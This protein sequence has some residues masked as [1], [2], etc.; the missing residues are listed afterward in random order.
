MNSSLFRNELGKF[1][2]QVGPYPIMEVLDAI[3]QPKFFETYCSIFQPQLVSLAELFLGFYNQFCPQSDPTC[4]SLMSKPLYYDSWVV[5]VS[6]EKTAS[7]TLYFN[8][9][10]A[11]PFHFYQSYLLD[12]SLVGVKLD[13][14]QFITSNFDSLIPQLEGVEKPTFD[15][16]RLGI[17]LSTDNHIKIVQIIKPANFSDDNEPYD[18][19]VDLESVGWVLP[20]PQVA[21]PAE[22]VL[23]T[24][25][26]ADLHQLETQISFLRESIGGISPIYYYKLN[27]SQ[28]KLMS[29][30]GISIQLGLEKICLLRD[31]LGLKFS[32]QSVG[33]I[34]IN[35]PEIAN[36]H[37]LDVFELVGI[38]KTDPVQLL[39]GNQLNFS[40]SIVGV[41]QVCRV[42]VLNLTL[43]TSAT[44][45][46]FQVICEPV[47]NMTAIFPTKTGIGIPSA[48][49]TSLDIITD[50]RG[51]CVV[52]SNHMISLE[53]TPKVITSSAYWI[54][55][56]KNLQ[57]NT[58]LDHEI[59]L[60]LTVTDIS[61][62]N[63]TLEIQSVIEAKEFLII[64]YGGSDYEFIYRARPESARLKQSKRHSGKVLFFA[65]R[66]DSRIV[67]VR[68]VALIST[69]TKQTTP[70]A[71]D[72]QSNDK[73]IRQFH[74]DIINPLS[75]IISCDIDA[76][77]MVKPRYYTYKI[78]T[79]YREFTLTIWTGEDPLGMANQ[80][81]SLRLLPNFY[82]I[83]ILATLLALGLF[84]FLKRRGN[85]IVKES[86]D[87]ILKKPSLSLPETQTESHRVK[88]TDEIIVRKNSMNT[89]CLSPTKHQDEAELGLN[90][91]TN[92]SVI[93]EKPRIT[94]SEKL[95][96]TKIYQSDFD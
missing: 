87:Q 10:E 39:S 16:F 91:E 83:G 53:N 70:Y 17:R 20:S 50:G 78:S 19:T 12:S 55:R 95:T 90:Q 21:N 27:A 84:C 88:I 14:I 44:K 49:N 93:Q 47:A 96:A 75:S 4:K 25:L 94:F 92:T 63:Q 6:K 48:T 1:Q 61:P 23:K 26:P 36:H 11:D 42:F 28:T 31:G 40:K 18:N 82:S 60:G 15:S 32:D 56:T 41:A 29:S 76:S 5:L 80:S 65:H 22:I 51:G 59:S 33:K 52:V 57:A 2:V 8:I 30:S 71:P 58:A 79:T 7:D 46:D 62:I 77:E 73:F 89:G 38:E 66:F 37:V 68:P 64:G 86:V 67:D 35:D 43:R 9:F 81:W 3:P 34:S 74:V 85:S 24:S 54:T 13:Q 69:G 72:V 45:I